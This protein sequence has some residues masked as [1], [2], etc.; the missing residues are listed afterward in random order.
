[1]MLVIVF[2]RFFY[3]PYHASL[4]ATISLTLFDENI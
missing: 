2:E 4:F 3:L 1:M